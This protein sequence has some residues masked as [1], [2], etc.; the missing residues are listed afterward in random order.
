MNRT[1]SVFLLAV[2]LLVSCGTKPA[3][4][5]VGTPTFTATPTL[6]PPIYQDASQ[7]IEA[8]VE[9]LLVRMTLDEKIG[10]MTQVEKTSIRPG[11][12]TNYF[13]GSILSGGD[14]NPS[15]NNPQAWQDMIKGFQTE[16]MAT[17]LKIPMIYGIDATH[18]NG[19]LYGGT[20]FPQEIGMA[21]TRD[22]PLVQEIGEATAEEILAT[23][24]P[25]TFSPIIAVPQDI[26][27]GRTYESFSED[28]QLVTDLGAAYIKGL[29]TLPDGYQAS[30]GQTLF[31]LATPKH[32]LGDGGTIWG[33]SRNGNY[34]LDQGNM[35]VNEETLRKLY[36]PPYKAAVKSGAM[37]IMASFSSW[38]GTKMHAQ[39]YL[40][41]DV[42]KNELG[43]TG[44]II[45]DWGGIDQIDPDYYTAVVTAINA[46][47]DMNMVPNDYV[48]FIGVMKQA[49]EKKD[50]AEETNK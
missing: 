22:L 42:L 11:D 34:M 32:F 7:P 2:I 38:K 16:A 40:L 6:P 49:I 14:S 27:W 30:A 43:F 39:R 3:P 8:R 13:I 47:V 44:F 21:A 48:S 23:G 20:I 35:Q 4:T 12:I 33:S 50:I 15:Q 37:S 31:T 5:Q 17:R 24:V 18:G 25:W 28:T 41:T 36:L 1:T 26:R 46:G 45:S 19:H 10:Q 9:D 29:Q